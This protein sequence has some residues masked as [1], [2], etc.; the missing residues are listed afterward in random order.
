ML[1]F[2]VGNNAGVI[3]GTFCRYLEWVIMQVFLAVHNFRCSEW[4]HY[5]GVF[6]C[7]LLQVFGVGTLCRYLE[8]EIMQEFWVGTLYR[9]LEWNIMQVFG[10]E[11]YAGVWSGDTVQVF[12]VGHYAGV[13]GWT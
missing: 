8:W 10:V 3:S 12:G 13:L 11:H 9:Y 4:R 2:G 5:A 6:S 7:T 1:V